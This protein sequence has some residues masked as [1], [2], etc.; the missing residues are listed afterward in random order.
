MK[1]YKYQFPFAVVVQ[2]LV[3]TL[4]YGLF[5]YLIVTVQKKNILKS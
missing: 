1:A 3:P 4:A 2:Y 5:S